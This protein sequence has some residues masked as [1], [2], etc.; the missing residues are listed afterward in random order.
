MRRLALLSLVLA[1]LA[2][3]CGDGSPDESARAPVDTTTAQPPEEGRRAF[4][5]TC[6][7]G[8]GEARRS[9]CGCIFVRLQKTASQREIEI[10]SQA[11][12]TPPQS[13]QRKLIVASEACANTR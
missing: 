10:L 11:G 6:A 3:G 12:R 1:A 8:K 2:A 7:E 5:E 9:L 4:I 13:A